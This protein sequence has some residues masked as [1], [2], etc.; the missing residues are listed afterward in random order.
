[1]SKSTY[2][3]SLLTLDEYKDHK[4]IIPLLEKPWWLRTCG[5]GT[6]LACYVDYNGDAHGY[7]SYIYNSNIS[8]RPTITISKP[9]QVYKYGSIITVCGYEWVV[10]RSNKAECFALCVV[11]IG[12]HRFNGI[13]G[14]NHY[15]SSEIKGWIENYFK[16]NAANEVT[17]NIDNEEN[18]N[19]LTFKEFMDMYDNW[20]GLL[21]INDKECNCIVKG[22]TLDIMDNR[23]DLYNKTVLSFGIYSGNS[24]ST[25]ELVVKINC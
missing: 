13:N 17:T 20:N 1:M 19:M 16:T 25:Y 2:R 21:T 14:N 23:S 9:E 18:N 3:Y 22:K 5:G 15:N 10:L 24:W 4:A 7:G 11:A 12:K 6:G 8:V